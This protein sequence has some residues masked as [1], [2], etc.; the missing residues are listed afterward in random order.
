V[1]D[2][3]QVQLQRMKAC[4]YR[5]S[6]TINSLMRCATKLYVWFL[7]V[8]RKVARAFLGIAGARIEL[9]IHCAKR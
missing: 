7:L 5:A 6:Y 8:T 9:R 1:P 2:M 3:L 4:N